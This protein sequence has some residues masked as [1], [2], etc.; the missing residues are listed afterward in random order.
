[1]IVDIR[2]FNKIT[3]FD[4]Y[5]LFFQ[6]DIIT[7]ITE[8]LY[9]FTINDNNYFHQFRVRHKDRYKF[10]IIFHRGQKQFNVTLMRYKGSSFYV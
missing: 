5:S 9:I 2:E 7:A 3:E 1:M 6:S 10:I 4:T 8:A